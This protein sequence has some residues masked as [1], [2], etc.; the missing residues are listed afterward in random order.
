MPHPVEQLIND[1]LTQF[2]VVINFTDPVIEEDLPEYNKGQI[3]E[4][5]AAILNRFENN[6][7]PHRVTQKWRLK[8]D[9]YGYLK[10]RLLPQM[11]RI[12]YQ[13]EEQEKQ[14]IAKIIVIGPKKNQEAYDRAKKRI[15]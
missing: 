8:G 15:K 5:M 10:I 3:T 9:L 6:G 12:V 13:V 14:T 7:N 1:Y 4:I 2:N 11:I